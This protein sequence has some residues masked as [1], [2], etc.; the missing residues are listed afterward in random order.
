MAKFYGN[1]GYAANVETAPSVFQEQWTI[2]GY[3]GDRMKISRKMLNE[4]VVNTGISISEEISIVADPYARHHYTEIRWV[5]LDGSKWR[6]TGVTENYPR[7]ILT[8]GGLYN[9]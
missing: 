4:G 3:K 1:V 8:L 9:A 2:R 6:V 7:L 5:E